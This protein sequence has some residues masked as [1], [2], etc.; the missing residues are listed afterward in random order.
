MNDIINTQIF[1]HKTLVIPQDATQDQWADIHKAILTCS[2]ASKRWL[3][4]SRS[5]AADKWGLDYAVEAEIQ[6]EMDLGFDPS[7]KSERIE[8][9][10][11]DKAKGL[12]T[13]EGI[14]QKFKLWHAKMEPEIKTWD[15]H[16]IKKALS[17]LEPIEA[18][19]RRLRGMLPT[20]I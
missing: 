9:N 12:V 11:Q 4:Q 20:P 13:I 8:L 5:F 2:H 16:K 6:M 19:A 1:Q 15:Q 18:E 14:A 3:K 7:S 17:I 10:P